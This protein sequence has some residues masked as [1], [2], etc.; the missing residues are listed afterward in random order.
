MIG[1][2]GPFCT[3]TASGYPLCSSLNTAPFPATRIAYPTPSLRP[4]SADHRRGC[5]SRDSIQP[6]RR[7]AWRALYA[8]SSCVSPLSCRSNGTSGFTMPHELCLGI[9]PIRTAFPK[10]QRLYPSPANPMQQSLCA[11][12]ALVVSR[13]PFLQSQLR[14]G[15]LCNSVRLTG[16]VRP[17]HPGVPV[18]CACAFGGDGCLA[19]S[20]PR[21]PCWL[22]VLDRSGWLG[23][24][25]SYRVMCLVAHITASSEA[26]LASESSRDAPMLS[27]SS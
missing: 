6:T 14:H 10:R 24:M 26:V 17:A 9:H 1:A 13:G 12:R 19:G 20:E 7:E 22:A 15:Y 11:R 23:R 4:R 3:C 8:A 16:K 27:I 25:N 2:S 5:P 21:N 18:W